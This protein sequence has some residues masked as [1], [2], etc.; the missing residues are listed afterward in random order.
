MRNYRE[1]LLPVF[2]E[3][4]LDWEDEITIRR[5]ISSAGKSRAFVDDVPVTLTV[6]RAVADRLVDIHSQH[7]TLLLAGTGFQTH[8][9]DAVAGQVDRVAEYT[10]LYK[11]LRV[12]GANSPGR[13][14]PTRRRPR[15]AIICSTNWN[16]SWL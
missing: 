5:T 12:C 16:N 9:V 3:N 11:R 13:S 8:L 10:A 6:L 4:D 14:R 2:E 1:D 15:S 7:Q